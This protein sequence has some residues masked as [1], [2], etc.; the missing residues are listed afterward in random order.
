MKPIWDFTLRVK[1]YPYQY[2]LGWK[3]QKLT[4]TLAYYDTE[5]IT[6]IKCLIDSAPGPN[7]LNFF[8]VVIYKC[9]NELG[10]LSLAGPSSL[11][12]LE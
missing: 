2:R 3:Q 6:D 8:T 10:W 4:N 1:P 9:S 11:D 12:K 5:L 7:V